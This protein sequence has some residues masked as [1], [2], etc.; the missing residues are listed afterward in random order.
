MRAI[1]SLVLLALLVCA[2]GS[3]GGGNAPTLFLSAPN[4]P[5]MSGLIFGPPGGAT[6]L[7]S[8][9]SLVWAGDVGN[10][11]QEFGFYRF[12]VAAIPQGS[13]I[14]EATFRVGQRTVVNSPFASLG[15]QV[16]VDHV[17]LGAAL[18]PAD[19][20]PTVYAM[21]VAVLSTSPAA[22]Q[23]S[24][25]IRSAVQADV[26][27]GRTHTDIRL[28]FPTPTNGNGLVDDVEFNN[29]ADGAGTGLRPILE[30]TY[31]LP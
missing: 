28:R 15:G 10:D 14:V 11:T 30:I 7:P 8:T 21:N 31:R 9:T 5:P 22:G 20:V 12:N 1:V 23:R 6:V 27:A 3:G 18:D 25:S 4:V 24:A 13:Q 19:Y 16:L 17:E 26:S 29:Q 2:C